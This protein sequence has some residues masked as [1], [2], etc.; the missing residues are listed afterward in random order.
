M[1]SVWKVSS[2]WVGD[3]KVF[4]VYRL[5]DINTVDHSG[6]RELYG[7]YIDSKEDALT[8]AN[9]LNAAGGSA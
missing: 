2:N 1:K 7:D 5:R 9:E 4:A 8:I 3:R 6:N